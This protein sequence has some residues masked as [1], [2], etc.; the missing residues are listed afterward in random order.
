MNI[1]G[2]VINNAAQF[3]N[4]TFFK[5]SYEKSLK[6]KE[7]A[8]RK[9]PIC[10]A[11]KKVNLKIKRAFFPYFLN[12]PRKKYILTSKTNKILIKYV[13]YLRYFKKFSV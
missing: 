11:R 6:L 12:L 7:V 1:I 8:L 4:K 10:N 3:V 13:E 5:G 2:I 9:I